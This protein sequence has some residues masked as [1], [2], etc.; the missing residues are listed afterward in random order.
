MSSFYYGPDDS[1]KLLQILSKNTSKYLII[2]GY[3]NVFHFDY[4]RERDQGE[5][6]LSTIEDEDEWDT[7]IVLIPT[8]DGWDVKFLHIDSQKS[9]KLL[10]FKHILVIPIPERVFQ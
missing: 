2:F 3:N 1:K 6:Y 8:K 10:S 9:E 5:L 7:D 4:I